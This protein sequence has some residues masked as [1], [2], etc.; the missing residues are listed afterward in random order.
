MTTQELSI[1]EYAHT[2]AQTTKEAFTASAR[3]FRALPEDAWDDPTGSAKWNMRTLAGHIVGEAVWFPNLVRGVTVG[4]APL[5]AH[6]YEDLKE[7]P[8]F[9]LADRTEEAAA[10]IQ[11]SVEEATHD[12]LELTVNVGWLEL[13]IWKATSISAAEAVLHD[14]DTR[15]RREER[16]RIPTPWAQA[17]TKFMLDFGAILSHKDGA[18][19]NPGAY[20]L[21]VGDGVGPITI[22]VREGTVTVEEGETISPDVILYLS[23]DQYVRLL[24][25]RLDLASPEGREVR[26]DGD[27]DRAIGLNRIFAGIANG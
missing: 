24:A 15:A 16:A 21:Q 6:L 1:E 20:L 26:T 5:P 18:R 10:A 4:E 3:Y 13:P 8:P 23:A 2:C 19:A 17:L 11:S 7:L 12:Q 9:E 27:R 22:S 14:W 25:G